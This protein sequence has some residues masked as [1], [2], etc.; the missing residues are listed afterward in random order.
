M[1]GRGCARRETAQAGA[2]NRFPA[3]DRDRARMRS[4]TG[5]NQ[6]WAILE[7]L[8][9]LGVPGI[10]PVSPAFVAACGQLSPAVFPG[11]RFLSDAY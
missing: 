7:L 2:S 11:V 4:V 8:N 9:R 1:A 10:P 3:K 6:I 5:A